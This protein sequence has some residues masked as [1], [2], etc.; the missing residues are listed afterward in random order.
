VA[1]S[2]HRLTETQPGFYAD[3]SAIAYN[4]WTISQRGVDENGTPWPLVFRSFGGYQG[5]ILTYLVAAVFAVTGPD[6]VAARLVGIAAGLLAAVLLGLLAVRITRRA[7]LGLLVAGTAALTPAL[8]E[9]G[10]LVQ[11]PNLMPVLVAAFLV[12]L[13]GCPP[14]RRWSWPAVAALA[15][16]LALMA[17]AYTLGRVLAPLLAAGLVLYLRRDTWANVARTWAVLAVALAPLIVYGWTNPG[18]LFDRLDQSGYLRGLAPPEAV[19]A[20]VSHYLANV[21]PRLQL[22][23]GDRIERHHVQGVMGAILAATFV[24]AMLGLGRVAHRLRRD[25]WWRFVVYGLAVSMIPASL[26]GDIGHAPRLIAMTVFL[27]ALGIPALAWLRAGATAG[28]RART[29]A[30]VL[31]VGATVAQAA[32]FQVR[33]QA[34][35]PTRGGWFDAEFPLLFDQALATGAE[36]IYLVDGIAPPYLHAWWYGVLR[37]VP[38]TRFVH[39]TGDARPPA[40]ATVI[41]GETDCRSCDVIAVRGFFRLYRV[42]PATG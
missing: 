41:S 35:G 38:A 15:V 27:I 31:L 37:G 29:V 5:S 7:E 28:S 34:V 2:L 22:L 13:H 30:L 42:L 10:R 25:P 40:G 18:L 26:T 23:V 6:I 9:V 19:A 8:F 20:F 14:D 21:D 11:E 3:E 12:V 17:Y 16:S 1:I 32:W 36:P 33:Y 39:L 4:A 24:L